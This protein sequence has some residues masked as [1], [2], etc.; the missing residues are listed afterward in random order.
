MTHTSCAQSEAEYRATEDQMKK[1]W[2]PER[3]E[4]NQKLDYKIPG[5]LNAPAWANWLQYC[6]VRGW[7]FVEEQPYVY[8]DGV[9]SAHSETKECLQMVRACEVPGVQFFSNRNSVLG[10]A[11]PFWVCDRRKGL[12]A[13][14]TPATDAKRRGPG[15]R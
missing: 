5:W 1:E 2:T 11:A 8:N 4:Q 6:K 10:G 13:E 14:P 9:M 15:S 12:T 3:A 7:M